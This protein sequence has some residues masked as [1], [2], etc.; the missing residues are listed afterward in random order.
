MFVNEFLGYC[1]ARN[2]SALTIRQYRMNLK[3]FYG[4][5]AE[6]NKDVDD[7][8]PQDVA[9]FQLSLSQRIKPQS[10]NACL[11]AVR[12]YFGYM[13]KFQGMA[14]NPAVQVSSCKTAKLLPKY[15]PQNVMER[16]L[17][18]LATNTARQR[19]NFALLAL[20][21]MTGARCAEVVS[22]SVS[23]LNFDECRI[24]LYGK[25]R[26]QRYVPMCAKLRHAL[27]SYLQV[28]PVSASNSIFLQ[29][30]GEPLNEWQIRAIVSRILAKY[31]PKEMAHPHIL[32]HT[33]ATVLLNHG[34]PIEQISRW[35]GHTSIAV[36][37]RYL[38]IAANPTTNNFN[39]VF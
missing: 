22:L 31:V 1:G 23:D 14:A 36:T 3:E 16:I 35:L 20:F 8:T 27:L 33:F 12:S 9:S 38:T 30:S 24:L 6:R 13:V 7:A 26:K 32:R 34:K 17:C 15:V 39:G 25:G 10:V 18:E 5:M 4:F 37:E 2:L 11:S 21:Y 28:R 29:V 19:R